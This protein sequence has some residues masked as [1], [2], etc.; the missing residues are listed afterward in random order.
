M[1]KSIPTPRVRTS[2]ML[3]IKKFLFKEKHE[4]RHKKKK[5]LILPKRMYRTYSDRQRA[6]V[7]ALRYGSL[8]NFS[9]VWHRPCEIAR[10]LN[11]S[12]TTVLSM[13]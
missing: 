9:N 6:L 11:M 4:K 8:Q 13:I 12:P 10:L 2:S 1:G 3:D 5:K 7:L